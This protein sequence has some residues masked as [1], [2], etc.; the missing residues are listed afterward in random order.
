ML[1]LYIIVVGSEWICDRWVTFYELMVVSP[2]EAESVARSCHVAIVKRFV[3][4]HVAEAYLRYTK[5][6]DKQ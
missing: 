5:R 2:E 3:T 4:L 6:R 1:P